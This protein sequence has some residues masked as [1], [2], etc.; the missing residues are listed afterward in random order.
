MSQSLSATAGAA[1]CFVNNKSVNKKQ[2][3]GKIEAAA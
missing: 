2:E 1:T 3:M